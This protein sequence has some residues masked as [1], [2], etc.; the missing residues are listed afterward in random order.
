MVPLPDGSYPLEHI[1]GDSLAFEPD[2]AWMVVGKADPRSWLLRYSGRIPAV[3]VKDIA[4]TGENLDEKGFADLGYGTMDWNTLWDASVG[5]GS[6]L[7]ILEH[8]LPSDWTRFARRS[9]E[10]MRAL[11]NRP[12]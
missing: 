4:P 9:I 1:L 5:A 11:G 6:Q 12:S 7:M 3:H 2:L 10:T 8:D